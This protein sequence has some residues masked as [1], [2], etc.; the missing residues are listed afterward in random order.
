[1]GMNDII[2]TVAASLVL[3]TF[4]TKQM[5]QLRALAIV[6]NFAFIA[7]GYRAGLMPILMLHLTMLP[8][9]VMRLQQESPEFR[10]VAIRNALWARACAWPR[11]R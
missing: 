6:S 5:V 8:I 4:C 7:Y 10:P 1:M 9:N 3:A 11:S 2:G